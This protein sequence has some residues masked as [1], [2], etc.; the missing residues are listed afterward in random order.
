LQGFCAA[1]FGA[2]LARAQTPVELKVDSRIIEVN[3]RAAK[4]FEIVNSRGGRGLSLMLGE[5]FQVRVRNRLA[6]ET[7]LHWHGLNP[8]S[9][10][11]GVPMLS[12]AAETYESFDY[13]FVNTRLHSLM[14]SIWDCRTA[15]FAAL[16]CAKRGTL[17]MNRSMW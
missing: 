15:V 12:Y 16:D 9:A 3:G 11:D 10:Q 17:F 14:H 4:V 6:D 1:P 2:G 8:P 13:D 7:L 5:R